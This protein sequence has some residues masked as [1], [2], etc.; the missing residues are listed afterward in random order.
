MTLVFLPCIAIK[1]GNYWIVALIFGNTMIVAIFD[2]FQSL[3]KRIRLKDIVDVIGEGGYEKTARF[4]IKHP[5]FLRKA[6][7]RGD[8]Q[9]IQKHRVALQDLLAFIRERGKEEN[10]DG[11]AGSLSVILSRF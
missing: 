10:W 5:K 4:L 1:E 11:D 7:V 2:I 3:Q 9:N 8:E 6:R